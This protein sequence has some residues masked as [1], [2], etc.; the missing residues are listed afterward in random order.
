[1]VNMFLDHVSV[2]RMDNQSSSCRQCAPLVSVSVLL[3]ALSSD[4]QK[5]VSKTLNASRCFLFIGTEHLRHQFIHLFDNISEG[6]IE[7]FV[8]QH[9]SEVYKFIIAAV[10]LFD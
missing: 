6:D 5:K 3:C 1:M 10:D 8:S 4:H 7:G 2:R 9:N